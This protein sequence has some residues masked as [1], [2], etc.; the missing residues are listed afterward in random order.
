M[1]NVFAFRW[2]AAIIGLK[3][4][5]TYRYDNR[6]E[7]IVGRNP[8][9]HRGVRQLVSAFNFIAAQ[10]HTAQG[11]RKLAHSRGFASNN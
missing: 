5:L 11:A 3:L 1:R 8:A 10:F 6:R 9:R 4:G 2:M 7:Q